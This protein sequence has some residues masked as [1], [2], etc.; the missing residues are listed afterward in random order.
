MGTAAYVEALNSGMLHQ[1][2]KDSEARQL[3]LLEE[4]S[5]LPEHSEASDE[6]TSVRSAGVRTTI[7][8]PSWKV[9]LAAP[10]S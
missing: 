7:H 3:D 5:N 1:R 4:F 9:P 2:G 8:P 10:E 6:V